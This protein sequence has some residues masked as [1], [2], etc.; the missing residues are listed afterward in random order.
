VIHRT[1]WEGIDVP[2]HAWAV[3]ITEKVNQITSLDVG[4][5]ATRFSPASGTLVWSSFVE[6]LTALETANAKLMVD[7]TFVAESERGAAFASPDG[8]DDEVAQLI[9]GEID[10]SR[11]PK[12]VA[13]V[14]SELAPGGFA[15]GIEA[16]VEIAQRATQVSGVPTAFLVATTGKYGGVRWITAAESLEELEQAEQSLNADAG[17]IQYLD[18]VAPGVFLPGITTQAIYSRIA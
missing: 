15:K 1:Q 2:I 18:G 6:D 4:L 16:G 9:H 17:F 3:G 5:W 12:Y 7:D 8:L 14:R 13:A 10:P 11:N